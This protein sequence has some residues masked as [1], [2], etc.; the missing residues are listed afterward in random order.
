MSRKIINSIAIVAVMIGFFVA[1]Y[2][3]WQHQVYYPSTDDAYIQAH[4]VNIAPQISGKILKVFVHNQRSVKENALLFE[5]DLKPFQ[6]AVQKAEANLNNVIQQV[7]AEQN[8]VETV[9]AE[10]AERQA[11]FTDARKNYHRIITLARKGFYSKAGA[12]DAL[13]AMIVAKEVV[14]ATQNELSE[15]RAKL[16]NLGD[17]NAQIEAAKAV[18]AQ[19]NLNLQYTKVYAPADGNLAKMTLQPGQTVNAYAVLFSLI[20][21]HHWWVMANM[22]ETDLTRIRPGQKASIHVDIYANHVFQGVVKSISPGSG[23]SFALLPA[24]NASGN[25]VKVTQRFPVRVMIINPD[26]RFPL[27]IG[28]SCS[29]VIDTKHE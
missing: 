4:V 11:Q 5:I 13:R 20:Q 28:A 25:W 8:A 2:S 14:I 1:G 16:G 22:K 9:K 15:A 19:A 6:I 3:Y 27:R 17:Q 21:D 10:L 29:V 24:E 12:D 7:K 18:L 26:D 23:A